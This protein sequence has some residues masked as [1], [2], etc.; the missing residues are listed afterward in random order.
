MI[1]F[2][3]GPMA[4]KSL[5]CKR[6]PLFLRVVKDGNDGTFDALDQ[7]H[8]RPSLVESITVYERVTKPMNVHVNARGASGW[9]QLADYH[10]VTPPP[11]DADVRDTRRWR[12]WAIAYQK[13]KQESL[14]S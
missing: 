13:R 1:R 9:Y 12:D 8:D 2:L 10:L 5:A 14:A 11:A 7:L 6:A 4:G 3:D